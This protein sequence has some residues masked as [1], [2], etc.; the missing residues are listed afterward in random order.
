MNSDDNDVDDEQFNQT[1]E[2][3]II[4][5]K[6][7]VKKEKREKAHCANRHFSFLLCLI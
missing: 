4:T 6:S 2:R 1:N 3:L 5:P 7:E